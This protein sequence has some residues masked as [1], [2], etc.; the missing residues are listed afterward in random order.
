V[1]SLCVWNVEGRTSGRVGS[2]REGWWVRVTMCCTHGTSWRDSH[3][4]GRGLG[5]HMILHHVGRWRC[6][7]TLCREWTLHKDSV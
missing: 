6:N 2:G 3:T 1:S 5:G 7:K 4:Q